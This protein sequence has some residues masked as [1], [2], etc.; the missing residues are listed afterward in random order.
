MEQITYAISWC[1]NKDPSTVYREW[2][3]KYN[4]DVSQ[5]ITPEMYDTLLWDFETR[6]CLAPDEAIHPFI[7][8]RLEHIPSTTASASQ[9]TIPPVP[10]Y[11]ERL[12]KTFALYDRQ[13]LHITEY[14]P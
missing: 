4:F 9:V 3:Q 10:T 13:V 7:R 14:G 5:K 2:Q 1:E 11:F 12:G 8:P 6:Y